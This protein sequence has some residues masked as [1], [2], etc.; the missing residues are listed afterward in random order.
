M[1]SVTLGIGWTS[2]IIAS[3][4]PVFS[5]GDGPWNPANLFALKLK[6]HK[7]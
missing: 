2:S 7:L 3:M 4:L 1:L 6:Y 5:P